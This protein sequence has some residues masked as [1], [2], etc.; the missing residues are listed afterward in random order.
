MSEKDLMDLHRRAVCALANYWGV[1][2]DEATRR[3]DIDPNGA[4][5]DLDVLLNRIGR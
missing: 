3:V 2:V 1:T 5:H 4:K